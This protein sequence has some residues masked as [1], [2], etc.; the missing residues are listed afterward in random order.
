MPEEFG[1]LCQMNAPL[2]SIMPVNSIIFLIYSVLKKECPG[3][4]TVGHR[5]PMGWGWR[6]QIQ[7]NS[8]NYPLRR[9]YDITSVEFSG[10]FFFFFS[11]YCF[12][13]LNRDQ[14]ATTVNCSLLFRVLNTD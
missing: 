2:G 5:E 14:L 12:H 9:P 3:T 8:T 6:W 10:D 11:I 7:M 1:R 4:L 13:L